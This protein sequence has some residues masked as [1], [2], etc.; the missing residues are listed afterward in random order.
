MQLHN[1]EAQQPH[2]GYGQSVTRCFEDKFG[3]F[4]LM[5]KNGR[6]QTQAQFCPFCGVECLDNT[7]PAKPFHVTGH[8]VAL[9]P[10][11]KP[12]RVWKQHTVRTMVR[13]SQ[14]G[15]VQVL[16][17]DGQHCKVRLESGQQVTVCAE[18]CSP[19]VGEKLPPR[20]V[21]PTFVGWRKKSS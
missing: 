18:N 5:D 8:E 20:I 11:D 10:P 15:T 21:A 7:T 16:A 13:H 2:Q 3:R 4:W 19:I 14:F 6:N 17:S 9:T 12:N 1:C